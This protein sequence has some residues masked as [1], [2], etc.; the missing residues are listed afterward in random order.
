M[1]KSLVSVSDISSYLF[2]ARKVFYRL[3]YKK[4]EP[5][6]EGALKGSIFHEA[7][8]R[9][10]VGESKM[11]QAVEKPAIENY[12]ENFQDKLKAVV[13]FQTEKL[14]AFGIDSHACFMEMIP[15]LNQVAEN[16]FE[17]VEKLV[18]AGVEGKELARAIEPKLQPEV[19]INSSQL[20][21][22]GK[23]DCLELWKDK[24]IPVDFKT[25]DLKYGPQH[26]DVLQITGYI[27]LL[28]N[29]YGKA[30][31]VPYGLLRYLRNGKDVKVEE[32]EENKKEIVDVAEKIRNMLFTK[33]EPEPCKNKFCSVC[34]GQ[35]S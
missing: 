12:Q 1:Q 5:Q 25:S 28:K 8:K 16:R 7:V 3:V 34:G 2:C 26:G 10:I 4:M 6:N 30:A 31:A 22:K 27:M 23:I 14:G 11:L 29:N 13:N 15:M 33:Q 24:V 35:Q 18:A 20:G 21:L 19:W 32:Q 17:H 9:A